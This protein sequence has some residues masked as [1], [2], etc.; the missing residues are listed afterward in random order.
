MDKW[1]GGLFSSPPLQLAE[2]DRGLPN[3][4][5]GK[6][7]PG[8]LPIQR[9]N[10]DQPVPLGPWDEYMEYKTDPSLH[11]QIIEDLRKINPQGED[12][13]TSMLK[14]Q[15]MANALLGRGII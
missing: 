11:N 7:F 2:Y 14:Q 10:A 15:Q 8:D 6:T 3:F 12:A 13:K 5:A 9:Q 4:R 1:I